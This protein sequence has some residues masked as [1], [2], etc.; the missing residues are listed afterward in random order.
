MVTRVGPVAAGSAHPVQ[1][2]DLKVI[3][4]MLGKTR[5]DNRQEIVSAVFL[6]ALMF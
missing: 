2:C 3:P 4:L 6:L 5:S 1:D